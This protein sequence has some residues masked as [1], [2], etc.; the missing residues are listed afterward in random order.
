MRSV[1]STWTSSSEK[2]LALVSPARNARGVGSILC[3]VVSADQVVDHVGVSDARFDRLGVVQ[4]VFL[5]CVRTSL[6]VDAVY[7]S[8]TYDKDDTAK[9]TGD[10]QVT[11]RHLLPK[12]DDDGASLA[13]YSHL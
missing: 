11:L 8:S 12:R 13:S 1:P 9:I 3:R 7:V 5:C 6:F 2:F 10:L 4:V